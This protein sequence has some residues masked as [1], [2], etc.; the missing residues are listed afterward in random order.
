MLAVQTVTCSGSDPVKITGQ[1]VLCSCSVD[2]RRH[3]RLLPGHAQPKFNVA[4]AKVDAAPRDA[5]L[6]D[7]A[8]RDAALRDAA[9]RR[10]VTR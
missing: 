2:L 4:S 5:A 1:R 6:T 10:I 7:A 8:P 3:R 9:P